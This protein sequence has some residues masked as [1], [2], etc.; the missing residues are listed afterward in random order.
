MRL[1][2]RGLGSRLRAWR[3]G[4]QAA[5]PF[6]MLTVLIDM[7]SIGL[8]VPVLPALVG[9]FTD[10]Q[11]DL[12]FW[13]G[14]V[15]F[16]FGIANFFGAPVL[17]AL[18]DTY[19]RRP[20]LL[21]GFCGLGLNLFATGLAGAL[22]VLVAVR[23]VAGALQA[24]AAVANAYVADITPPEARTRRF[25]L[26]GA[27]T[28]VGFIIGPVAG[29]LLGAVDLRL[30]FFA[31]GVLSMVNLLY[32]V[33]VMP[34]SLPP[35]R[36]RR[37]RWKAANPLGA[38]RGLARLEGVGPLMAVVA[39]NALAQFTG[40]ASWVLFATF[41]FGWGPWENGWC[42]AASGGVSV[43]VQGLM[44]GRLLRHFAPFRLALAGLASAALSYA[45]FG[46]APE[47]W[48]LYA[49]IVLNL[50]GY[51]VLPAIQGLIS[52][53]ATP[54]TQGQVMGAVAALNSLMAVLAPMLGA[55]LLALVSGL[56]RGDW[57]IGVPLYFCAALEVAA[58]GCA[59]VQ[60]RQGRKTSF[61]EGS[62]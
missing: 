6:V 57:R 26:L 5:M 8:I 7:I 28:G 41:K 4:S 36:R 25:G 54:R 44:M 61:P 13:F 18:S 43:V 50:F 51:T 47:G 22:W 2:F 52:A 31:G 46:A 12:S 10:S 58:L 37:F 11:G 42:L 14:A 59:L 49:I 60:A 30:P 39:F 45:A 23:L 27:M 48:M 20:I 38:L 3:R 19:G 53:A 62:K 16:A 1:T 9:G 17:G 32:G 33:F 24:N 56:P 35:A 55:P 40:Y 29:G 21:L 15:V 34:E